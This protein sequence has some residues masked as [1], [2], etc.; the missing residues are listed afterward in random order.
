MNTQKNI[1]KV[2]SWYGSNDIEVD[3]ASDPRIDLLNRKV[4]IDMWQ[5]NDEILFTA[6]HE[7]GHFIVNQDP[8]WKNKYPVRQEVRDG[9]TE[10][11]DI[12][13]EVELLHEEY[14]AWEAGRRLGIE[15]GFGN[16]GESDS[17]IERKAQAILSYVNFLSLKIQDM[18]E[19]V[20]VA[21]N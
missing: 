4:T 10:G 11:S 17:W 20:A 12:F 21:A 2:L 15:L 14:E 8:D 6:L 9:I 18:G 5:T 13:S 7:A 1:E 3:F 16:L 19:K